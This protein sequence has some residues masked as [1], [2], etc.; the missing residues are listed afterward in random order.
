MKKT[1]V[2]YNP[3]P[4]TKALKTQYQPP[5]KNLG[6][7]SKNIFKKKKTGG[8]WLVKLTGRE[9]HLSAKGHYI[10]VGICLFSLS[11]CR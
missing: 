9:N 8:H 5:K 4:S 10:K 11:Y 6:R 2:V 7:Y 3:H 1:D